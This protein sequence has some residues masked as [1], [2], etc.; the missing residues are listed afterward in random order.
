MVNFKVMLVFDIALPNVP[1][2]CSV[3]IVPKELMEKVNINKLRN[4]M[5]FFFGF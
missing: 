5:I 2:W 1:F 4:K 3:P